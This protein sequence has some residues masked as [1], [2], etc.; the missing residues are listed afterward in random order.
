MADL[1]RNR[2]DDKKIFKSL[3]DA[4]ERKTKAAESNE[5]TPLRFFF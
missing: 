5:P 3:A 4:G 1:H 2:D